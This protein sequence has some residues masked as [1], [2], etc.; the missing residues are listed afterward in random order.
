MNG[1]QLLQRRV[2]NRCIGCGQ[3]GMVTDGET[4]FPDRYCPDCLK[5]RQPGP[6]TGAAKLRREHKAKGVQNLLDLGA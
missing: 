4:G 2:E 5:E 1:E 3:K 6:Q